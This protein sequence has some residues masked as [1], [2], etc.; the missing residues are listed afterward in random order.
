MLG[1]YTAEEKSILAAKIVAWLRERYNQGPSGC[2]WLSY[3]ED[4][5]RTVRAID[6]TRVAYDVIK[7][8]PDSDKTDKYMLIEEINK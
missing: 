4:K 5:V 8:Y 3:G 7:F 1:P 6:Q 2:Q